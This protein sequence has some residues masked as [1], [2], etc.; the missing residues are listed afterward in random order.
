MHCDN[1]TC[2]Q[3]CPT[4]ATY[5][6]DKD[7]T[8]KVNKK[9]C[10]G[11]GSCIPACPYGARYRH[12]EEKVVDKCDFCV[13]RLDQ[14]LEPACVATC[15][16]KAIVLGNLDDPHSEVSRMVERNDVK[17]GRPLLPPYFSKVFKPSVYYIEA[18]QVDL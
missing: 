18:A 7:G 6:D 13:D 11:C 3:A 16:G 4:S 1:P 10:I 5:K 14:G 12:P 15:M 17:P 9:L 2:V 8:I